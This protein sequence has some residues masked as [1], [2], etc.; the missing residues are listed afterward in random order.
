MDLKLRDSAVLITGASQGIGQALAEAFAEEG[1][2]LHLVARSGQKLEA[3]ASRLASEHG[4]LV[5]TH[6]LDLTEAGAIE[7]L[8]DAVGDVDIIVN[9]A[10]AIP[11][12]DLWA[13]DDLRWRQ[14]WDLKVHGYINLTR[15][16]YPRMKARGQGVIVNVIGMGGENFD[17]N[18]IAGSTGNAGL[19]AFTRALGG[20]SLDDGVRVVGVNPGAVATERF[21]NFLK[22][23]A[24]ERLGDAARYEELLA[25]Y[26]LQRAADPREIADLVVFLAS[27]RSG[28]T[29]GSIFTVDG[30]VTSRRSI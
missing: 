9:N 27:P 30:G 12:G 20:R 24:A 11:A 18:Y 1:A 7:T 21:I 25:S 29:S 10:G 5:T 23:R 22:L 3:I 28:Y 16:A 2:K 19:M 26:P 6:A 4:V 14:A 17:F 8:V 15:S 13:V